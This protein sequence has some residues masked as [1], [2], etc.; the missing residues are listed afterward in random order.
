MMANKRVT[1]MLLAELGEL[2]AKPKESTNII[3]YIHTLR[4]F[5]QINESLL[6]ELTRNKICSIPRQFIA[7]TQ[8]DE[9]KK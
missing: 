2:A 7:D 6:P 9:R 8:N 5:P 1:G 3:N 4:L